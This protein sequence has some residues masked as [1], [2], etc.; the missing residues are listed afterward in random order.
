V[1]A[2]DAAAPRFAEE[3]EEEEEKEEEE[4]IETP[5]MRAA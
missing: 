4:R 5:W 1:R 2:C 3:E